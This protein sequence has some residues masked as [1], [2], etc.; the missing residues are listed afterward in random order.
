MTDA[1]MYWFNSE[2]YESFFGTKAESEKALPGADM[3]FKSR[4]KFIRNVLWTLDSPDSDIDDQGFFDYL[5]RAEFCDG[6]KRVVVIKADIPERRVL[7]DLAD[8]FFG[9]PGYVAL[10]KIVV[11][12]EFD[13]PDDGEQ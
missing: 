4:A 5:T 13:D 7:E 1:K 10:P 11:S 3:A 6:R 12:F 8:R 9:A 2:T